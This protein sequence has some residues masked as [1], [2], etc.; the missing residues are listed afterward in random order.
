MVIYSKRLYKRR[1]KSHLRKGF[2]L[3]T[4]SDT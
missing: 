1:Y 2:N 3:F 4:H